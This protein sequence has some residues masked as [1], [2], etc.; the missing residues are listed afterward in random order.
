[1]RLGLIGGGNMAHAI[2][3]AALRSGFCAA[4][5]LLVSEPSA[6]RRE[7]FA[8]AGVRT[9]WDNAAVAAESDVLI[10]AVKPQ[11]MEAALASVRTALNPARTLVVSIAAGRRAGQIEQGLPAGTRVVRVM[12]NTPLLAGVGMSVLAAGANA[13]PDDV[14]Q[15]RTL[16]EAGG[17]VLELAEELFD[18]VTAVSGSGP[19]YFFLLV[20]ALAAAGKQVGIPPEA[21]AL[22]ARQ[23]FVGA[24]RLLESTDTPVETLRR[25]VTSPGGTTAAAIETFEA[26]GLLDLVARAVSAATT[27]GRELGQ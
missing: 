22:L 13:T 11:V 8:T 21:A 14:L 6:E 15:V 12:P 25:Q 5:D 9:V 4:S 20:E 3:L 27:R 24:A 10:L 16:F 26:G 2:A 19:A 23:T 1:M 7:L 18:A 17:R